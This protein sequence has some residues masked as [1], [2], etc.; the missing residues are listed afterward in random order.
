[1]VPKLREHRIGEIIVLIWFLRVFG[2]LWVDKLDRV[3]RWI[4]YAM[5]HNEMP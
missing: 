5:K 4:E 2:K 1:M 3:S